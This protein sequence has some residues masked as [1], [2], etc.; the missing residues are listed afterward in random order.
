[1]RITRLLILWAGIMAFVVIAIGPATSYREYDISAIGLLRAWGAVVI[2]T[3]GLLWTEAQVR[4]RV[5]SR[6]GRI[7]AGVILGAPMFWVAISCLIF[8]VVE[9]WGPGCVAVLDGPTTASGGTTPYRRQI[10]EQDIFD[11]VAVQVQ[12]TITPEQVGTKLPN[13]TTKTF[14][15]DELK[16]MSLRIKINTFFSSKKMKPYEDFYGKTVG[17]LQDWD[18]LTPPQRNNRRKVCDWAQIHLDGAALAGVEMTVAEA[19]KRGHLD[20]IVSEEE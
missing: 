15:D 10:P 20:F 17:N 4:L 5:K 9:L 3:G 13:Q 16:V 8:V 11:E 2:L 7:I 12:T 1:M 6:K 14:T 18:Y 19:L